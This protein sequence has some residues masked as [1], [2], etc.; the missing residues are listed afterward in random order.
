M[1]IWEQD[2]ASKFDSYT[3]QLLG[4]FWLGVSFR[5]LICG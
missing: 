4:L 3:G 2:K 1:W 5:N